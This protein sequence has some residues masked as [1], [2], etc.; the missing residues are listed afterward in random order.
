MAGG[1]PRRQ[2]GY[3]AAEGHRRT[4]ARGG[5]RRG[6]APSGGGRGGAAPAEAGGGPAG[7]GRVGDGRVGDDALEDCAVQVGA[8]VQDAAAAAL[9]AALQEELRVRAAERPR[10]S[11]G[12][13]VP[14]LP[15]DAPG[16]RHD[17]ACGLRAAAGDVGRER[18]GSAGIPRAAQALPTGTHL[19]VGMTSSH[20][21]ELQ[22]K[23]GPRC[24]CRLPCLALVQG[25]PVGP[26]LQPSR[27]PVCPGTKS[28]RVPHASPRTSQ[29]VWG[30]QE[31]PPSPL[32]SR[33]N[34]GLCFPLLI[35]R[36]QPLPNALPP[37][38]KEQPSP[39]PSPRPQGHTAP[40]LRARHSQPCCPAGRCRSAPAEPTAL[41]A[42]WPRRCPHAA[43]RLSGPASGTP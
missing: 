23:Q 34:P 14:R 40:G 30:P 5:C 3:G 26:G 10:G 37:G 43:R 32:R 12:A 38:G 35:P 7:G 21:L 20:G 41:T 28:T 1:R 11:A 17:R 19:G 31:Q 9:R 25:I 22:G 33:H 36:T 6:S 4:R 13:V 8:R 15:W 42:P 18:P 2:R 16:R 24:Q 39:A 27:G 29:P